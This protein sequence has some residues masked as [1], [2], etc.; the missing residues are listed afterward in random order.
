MFNRLYARI[1]R[2]A[3]SPHAIWWLAGLTFAEASVLPLPPESMLEPMV[4]AQRD[5]AWDY[6]ALCTLCSV[7]SRLLGWVVGAN[8]QNNVGKPIVHYNNAENV[9][10]G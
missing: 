7:S 1:M 10:A 2:H 5:R 3:T 8:M 9:I 4:L 6:D